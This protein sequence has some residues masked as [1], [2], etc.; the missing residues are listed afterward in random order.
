MK[1][2][3]HTD[4]SFQVWGRQETGVWYNPFIVSDILGLIHILLVYTLMRSEGDIYTSFAAPRSLCCVICSQAQSC[5]CLMIHIIAINLIRFYTTDSVNTYTRCTQALH[6]VI[7]VF[8]LLV[9]F[10]AWVIEVRI[11]C[12][13]YSIAW[14]WMWVQIHGAVTEDNKPLKRIRFEHIYTKMVRPSPHLLLSIQL[15]IIIGNS[16]PFFGQFW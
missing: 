7:E 8:T 2:G 13:L 3:R 16:R 6:A 4:V 12:A 15:L 9:L 11:I 5:R 14:M 1:E 10:V